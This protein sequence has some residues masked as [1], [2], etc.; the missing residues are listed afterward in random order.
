MHG[1]AVCKYARIAKVVKVEIFGRPTFANLHLA[2]LQTTMGGVHF[3]GSPPPMESPAQSFILEP[4][5]TA[6]FCTP[7]HTRY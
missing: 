3:K 4:Y 2:K 1:L 6:N 5:F 7:L